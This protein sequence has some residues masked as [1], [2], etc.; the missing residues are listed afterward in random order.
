MQ[1]L[2]AVPCA[3]LTTMGDFDVPAYGSDQHHAEEMEWYVPA[4]TKLRLTT[5]MPTPI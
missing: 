2:W 1:N 3:H 5:F 4:Y